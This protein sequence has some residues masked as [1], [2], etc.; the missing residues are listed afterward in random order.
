MRQL[1]DRG[2][3]KPIPRMQAPDKSW[4]EQQST[5]VMNGG[6]TEVGCNGIPPMRR[7]NALEVLRDLIKTGQLPWG[8][9][10]LGLKGRLCHHGCPGVGR[11]EQ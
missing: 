11:L 4:R 7:V 8:R 2:C 5:I 10:T 6:I 1:V 3:G 9:C